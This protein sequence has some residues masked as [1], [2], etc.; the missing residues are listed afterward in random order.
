MRDLR[1]TSAKLQEALDKLSALLTKRPPAQE[2]L[3]EFKMVLDRA[4]T[5]VLGI[6]TA[7]GP[8]DYNASVRRLRFRRAAQVCQSVL[9]SMY[10]G[11][12]RA[13]APGF[14]RLRSVVD[15]SLELLNR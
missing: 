10:D 12:V 1:T 14:D 2:A 6:A 8:A 3:E 5:S 15:E 9:Y 7:E 13:E 4:R 11:D